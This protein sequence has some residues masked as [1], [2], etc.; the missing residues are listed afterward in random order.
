MSDEIYESFYDDDVYKTMMVHFQ[1]GEWAQGFELLDQLIAKYPLE[2]ELRALRQEMLMRATVDRSEGADRRALRWQRF[3]RV[4]LRVGIAALI[5]I[6][7]VVGATLYIDNANAAYIEFIEEMEERQKQQDLNY[8]YAVCERYLNS[9]RPEDCAP[10]IEDIEALEPEFEGL[11]TL[12]RAV[13]YQR[14]LYDEYERAQDLIDEGEYQEALVILEDLE[15]VNPKFPDLRTLILDITDKY[16]LNELRDEGD[17][18]FLAGDWQAAIGKYEQIRRINI[19]YQREEIERKLY[20]SYI[21]A[22]QD[23]INNIQDVIDTSLDVE[24]GQTDIL[25]AVLEEV[26]MANDYYANA[27]KIRPRDENIY[28]GLR[29]VREQVSKAL[30]DTYLLLAEITLENSER[31]DSLA[32]QRTVM[33]YYQKAQAIRP[34]DPIIIEKIRMAQAYLNAQDGFL[35]E[36]WDAVIDNLELVYRLDPDYAS[37]AAE[38]TLYNAYIQRGVRNQDVGL[39]SQAEAD[40]R[41][42]IE[43]ARNNPENLLRNFE[44]KV[45]LGKLQRL[46]GYNGEAAI[47][48]REA[49]ED[50]DIFE[51]L[52]LDPE[53]G[54]TYSQAENFFNRNRMNEAAGLYNELVDTIFENLNTLI[55]VFEGGDPLQL[56]ARQYCTTV[57]EILKANQLRNQEDL[58]PGE[59]LTIPYIACDN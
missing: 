55:I 12:K 2:E 4:A 15:S 10:I 53:L 44:A 9:Y 42:A 50:A 8:Q 28:V 47:Q 36:N 14:T 38:D 3:K 17:Q 48:F 33:E 41:R 27:L 52:I 37:G 18:A 31:A 26:D 30:F 16:L 21:N 5:I 49:L 19:E 7:I 6:P 43:I 11:G 34:N 23:I 46:M 1:R 22:A 25:D 45:Q 51:L 29:E 20:D 58:L 56:L 24:A 13:D 59:R 40:Y 57:S 39:R 54:E 35:N 32:V